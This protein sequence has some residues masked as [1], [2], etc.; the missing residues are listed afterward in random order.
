MIYLR[1]CENP[2]KYYIFQDQEGGIGVSKLT[3]KKTVLIKETEDF[4]SLLK[5]YNKIG[6][7]AK[8]GA[9]KIA[10]T[11]DHK[12]L[13]TVGKLK[14]TFWEATFAYMASKEK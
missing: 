2:E 5:M 6:C 8:S 9:I 7:P 10:Y 3:S 13:L 12:I 4:I 11:A 1:S 14:L